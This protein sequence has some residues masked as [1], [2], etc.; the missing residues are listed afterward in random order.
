MVDARAG[1]VDC[2][3]GKCAAIGS[4]KRDDRLKIGVVLKTCTPS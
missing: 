2:N 4:C 3:D 1:M